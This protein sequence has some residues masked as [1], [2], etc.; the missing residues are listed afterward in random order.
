MSYS[1]TEKKMWMPAVMRTAS[2]YCTPSGN[3]LNPFFLLPLA[4]LHIFL[5]PSIAALR[6]IPLASGLAAL[7]LNYVLCGRAFDRRTAIVSTWI[8]ALLPILFR[9]GFRQLRCFGR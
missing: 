2:R 8:L 9:S 5:P 7:G 6:L 3:P 1:A 4:A